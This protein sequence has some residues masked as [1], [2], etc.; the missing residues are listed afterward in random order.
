MDPI[1]FLPIDS[2]LFVVFIALDC[3]VRV[4]TKTFLSFLFNFVLS[5]LMSG[6]ILL[7]R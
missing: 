2:G 7:D 4:G 5:P 6:I 1:R 3:S